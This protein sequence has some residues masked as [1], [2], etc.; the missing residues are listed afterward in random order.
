MEEKGW[1]VLLY[2]RGSIEV[3]RVINIFGGGAGSSYGWL[4]IRTGDLHRKTHGR[5]TRTRGGTGGHSLS[6]YKLRVVGGRHRTGKMY[7]HADVDGA[8]V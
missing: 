1:V 3:G 6:I 7:T 5:G 8:V 4:F 2:D